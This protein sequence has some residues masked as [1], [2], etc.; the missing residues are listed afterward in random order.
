MA[1]AIPARP[2][3]IEKRAVLAQRLG[4]ILHMTPLVGDRQFENAL[5]AA[6]RD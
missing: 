5:Q 1:R 4:G 6:M 2:L 3:P